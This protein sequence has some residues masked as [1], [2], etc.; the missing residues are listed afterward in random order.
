MAMIN[1]RCLQSAALFTD[2]PKKEVESLS[3]FSR[4][5]KI[6]RG[7]AVFMQDDPSNTIFIL[8][9]GII[10]ISRVNTDGRKLSI[11]L[12]EPGQFFGEL[13]LAGEKERRSFAEAMIDSVCCEIDK[14][15]FESFMQKR[16]GFALT[17]IKLIGDRRLLMENLLQHMA[18]MEISAR[19]IALLLKYADNNTVKIPLTH[20]EIADLTGSTRVSVSRCI[21]KLRKDGL[22]QTAGE[23]IKLIDEAAL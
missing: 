5:Q 8:Q 23:R 1:S 6:G 7:D 15:H 19:V 3:Q 18:F 13:C 2:L 20:Q 11:D 16:P 4:N 22:I 10:K 12:I 17:L 9:Q 21:A 14:D